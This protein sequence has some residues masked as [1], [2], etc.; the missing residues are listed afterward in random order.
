MKIFISWSGDAS[1]RIAVALGLWLRKVIQA[2]TPFVSTEIEKG[3]RWTDAIALELE[4]SSF[5]IIVLT[6]ENL[7][8]D[9]ILFEAGALSK[10]I[11][12]SRVYTYLCG[13]LTPSDIE[14]PLSQFQ[15][16]SATKEETKRLVW[17]INALLGPSAL[18]TEIL[19]ELF[20][21]WWPKLETDIADALKARPKPKK[22]SP[23]DILSEV[24]VIVRALQNE[25]P[26]RR[27]PGAF[28]RYDYESRFGSRVRATPVSSIFVT[29]E[30]GNRRDALLHCGPCGG[31]AT[32]IH[33][34][35]GEGEPKLDSV[36]GVFHFDSCQNSEP[37]VPIPILVMNSAGE[38][39]MHVWLRPLPSSEGEDGTDTP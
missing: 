36:L 4:G 27:R 6:P 7:H 19:A 31:A 3:R 28:V 18:T 17:S 11:T 33:F 13:G 20:E 2:V 22:R 37:G 21:V 30:E 24:L 8:A 29:G 39:K 16:T 12:E 15:H 38:T 32:R 9:W 25:G 10:R 5:G 34:Y 26:Q 14:G 35:E 1:Q 23:D